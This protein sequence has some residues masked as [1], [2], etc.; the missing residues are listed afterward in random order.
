MSG[1]TANRAGS[2]PPPPCFSS[3]LDQR[4]KNWGFVDKFPS[5]RDS[6][7]DRR[8]MYSMYSTIQYCRS[9]K[10]GDTERARKRQ[11]EETDR[12]LQRTRER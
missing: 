1:T 10:I 11:R 2:A 8:K 3:S 6:D 4:G 7:S 9:G 12:M 5:K